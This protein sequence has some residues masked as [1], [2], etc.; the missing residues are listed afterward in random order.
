MIFL[1]PFLYK[2]NNDSFHPLICFDDTV[3]AALQVRFHYQ[4][5]ELEYL[6]VLGGDMMKMSKLQ[7][8]QYIIY[9]R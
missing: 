4:T 8:I 5:G 2:S 9:K 6:S 1:L 7:L 3:R